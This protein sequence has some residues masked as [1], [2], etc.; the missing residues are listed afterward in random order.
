VDIYGYYNLS[1]G[2]LANTTAQDDC[3]GWGSSTGTNLVTGVFD[4]SGGTFI[5]QNGLYVGND[6]RAA[7]GSVYGVYNL[8][9]GT[10]Q[11]RQSSTGSNVVGNYSA[12]VLNL[13]GTGQFLGNADGSTT[14]VIGQRANSSGIVNL[15]AVDTGGGLLSQK[16]ITRGSGA[17]ITSTG[18]VNFHGGTLQACADTTDFLVR[19]TN[20]IYGEGAIIDTNN[21]NATITTALQAPTD[22]WIGGGGVSN[23]FTI[24]GGGAGYIGAPA[25]RIDGDGT[26]AT[27]V[28][29]VSGGAVTG[30][31]I[32]N[33][34]T[35]YTSAPTVTLVGGGYTT[36]ATVTAAAPVANVATGGLTKKGAGRLRLTAANT[37]GGSTVIEKGSL[38]VSWG[39]L[40]SSGITVQN[41]ATLGGVGYTP[42]PATTV[43]TG[44]TVDP[45]DPGDAGNATG[46]LRTTGLALQNKSRL[47]FDVSNFPVSGVPDSIQVDGNVTPGTANPTVVVDM[48]P[49][50]GAPPAT[51]TVLQSSGGTT[52]L[53]PSINFR[54][55]TDSVGSAVLDM[56]VVTG[57]NGHVDVAFTPIA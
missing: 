16:R 5:H 40:A 41:G 25:V 12:G 37:Y 18:L 24:T 45:G 35:G 38:I 44:G 10:C 42:L 23:S 4:Q 20:Y 8:A 48:S 15:G 36:L 7:P 53:D 2:M 51:A 27:A 3:I 29:T 54:L 57:V 30:I 47:A 56:N 9:G 31:T 32:T 34:G 33:P 22:G 55:L 43:E 17:T 39:S 1:G 21:Y 46:A 6:G 50:L 19:T 13:S 28:A 11:T 49:T 26:G 14:L 52:G